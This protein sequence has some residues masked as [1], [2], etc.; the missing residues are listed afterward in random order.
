MNP[1]LSKKRIDIS[2]K[3]EGF[4]FRKCYVVFRMLLQDKTKISFKGNLKRSLIKL[5]SLLLL[6]AALTAISYLFY[7]L[8]IQFNIFAVIPYVPLAVPSLI[9]AFLMVFGFFSLLSGLS[10]SL[11]NSPDNKILLTY[12]CSGSTI[13]FARLMVYFVYEAG[14]NIFIQV[15]LLL[16][17]MITMGAPFYMFA[18]VFPS[19]IFLSLFLVMLASVLALPYYLISSFLSKRKWLQLP[20]VSAIAIFL[21]A[22]FVYIIVS[23]PDTVDIFTNWGYY[24]RIIQNVVNGYET[25]ASPFYYLTNFVIG[26]LSGFSYKPFPIESLYVF[27]FLVGSI[28]LLSLFI[29]FVL[30]PYYLRLSSIQG[31]EKNKSNKEG[32]N[33]ALSPWKSQLRKELLLLKGGES[34]S[35]SPYVAAFLLLPFLCLGLGKFFHGMRLSSLGEVY[36]ETMMLL[37][38]LLITLASTTALTHSFSDEEGAY[39]LTRSYPRN[40]RLFILSKMAVPGAMGLTS[41]LASIICY[42]AIYELG[43]GESIFLGL[44]LALLFLGSCLVAL[45]LDFVHP[46]SK[47]LQD[48][49]RSKAEKGSTLLAFVLSIAVSALFY[50]YRIDGG[51]SSYIKL[52]AIGAIYFAITASIFALKAKYEGKEDKAR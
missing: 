3:K 51:L 41:I 44:A 37:T 12:P 32:K 11:F 15:P 36:V 10:K 35:L 23:L 5:F 42:G 2:K 4:S 43:I 39:L 17:F 47:F 22:L 19:F 29:Y 27:L 31:R 14:R 7:F 33:I 46:Q 20:L 34:S 52:F 8:V 1:R 25:Y 26:D 38:I 9:M 16:G 28:A 49:S 24:F 40:N 18:Y 6:F 21:C 13:F 30:N 50:L 45:F 48:G